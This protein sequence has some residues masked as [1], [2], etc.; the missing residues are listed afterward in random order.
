[1]RPTTRAA[2]LPLRRLPRLRAPRAG[3]PRPGPVHLNVPWRDPLAP[4]PVEGDVTATD[5]LALE[6]RGERA[7]QRR[8]PLQRREPTTTLLDELA[9]R[10]ASAPRGLILAGRQTDPSLAEPV[11]ALAEAARLS[12]P[13]RA[14]LAAP[15]RTHD[16]SLVDRAYDRSRARRPDDA[17]AR[18][19]RPLRRHAD[20]QAAAPVA[21]GDRGAA[22]RSS[23]TRP[24]TG[25]SRPGR[26]ETFVR[27]D[28]AA[29][30]AALAERLKRGC[31]P[32]PARS[33]GS[34]GSTAWL[35]A[36][37]RCGR[38]VDDELDR[39]RRAQRARRLAG[40]RPR[41]ARRRPGARRVEHARARPGGVP[42]RRPRAGPVL[43]QPRRQRDRRTGLDGRRAWPPASGRTWAVLG[44][45]ALAHDLGGLAAARECRRPAP[46]RHRQRRRRDLPLPAQAD[47]LGEREFEALLGTPSGLDLER[48]RR[49][50]TAST[51]V[52]PRT[53]SA[54]R[55][56]LAGDA[57]VIVVR[58]D[59]AE[60]LEL[61]RRLAEAA[62]A[63]LAST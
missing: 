18:A 34:G 62:A 3:D 48:A 39:A 22:T 44:D 63:A 51:T 40:A 30:A 8:R 53:T 2:P 41:P 52:S 58:T 38:R 12:D 46:A 21:G 13:G 49:R 59:R 7:A 5:P 27:A 15:L 20:Q 36:E 45:L 56:A 42:A 24:A 55:D 29:T 14:D 1:M 19:D 16:R 11:A 17:R 32:A 4:T 9:E 47:A 33:R 6:G 10:I 26:A 50:S 43:R 61:H 60:N 54:L 28:P 25:T 35:A 37:R 31:G 23:S 57:R